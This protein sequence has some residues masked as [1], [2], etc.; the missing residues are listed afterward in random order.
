MDGIDSSNWPALITAF[1]TAV[2]GIITIILNHQQGKREDRDDESLYALRTRLV[3]LES[4]VA[5]LSRQ[6]VDAGIEPMWLDRE[7]GE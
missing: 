4:G 7:E 2:G 5:I 1:A 6:L 3:L